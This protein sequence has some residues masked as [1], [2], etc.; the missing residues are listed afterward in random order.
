ML[1]G[2]WGIKTSANREVASK[3]YE[4]MTNASF[5]AFYRKYK[6]EKQ[7]DQIF[8]Q[9]YM[10]S[11]VKK[12]VLA[13]DSFHCQ[14]YGGQPFPSK[15]PAGYC[16]VGGFGCCGPESSNFIYA[17]P[18]ECNYNCRSHKDWVLC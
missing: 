5:L 9:L 13:H 2:M 18:H 3:F 1:A 4:T 6:Y 12:S 16:H 17:F 7:A 10:Y 11:D 15:R 8:L 14:K